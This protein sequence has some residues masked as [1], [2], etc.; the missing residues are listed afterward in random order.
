MK[1]NLPV[2]DQ[3]VILPQAVFFKERLLPPEIQKV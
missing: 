2:T 3:E 1:K